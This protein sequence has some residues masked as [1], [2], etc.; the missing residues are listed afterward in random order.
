LSPRAACRLEQL[1]FEPVYDYVAGKAAWLAE[2]L[3]GDGLVRDEDRAG[4]AARREVPTVDA[5]ATL[6]DVAAVVDDW[7][8][9]V[10]IGGGVVVGVVRAE[11]ASGPGATHVA[12][13]MDTAPSTVRPNLTKGELAKDMDRDRVRRLLV[14]T[15][16]GRLIGLLRREDL[17]D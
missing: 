17:D 12:A 7:E 9:V 11:A 6:R 15:L 3:P 8:L 16:G 5:G 4:A 2:G 1:G 13:I 10:V 14:T